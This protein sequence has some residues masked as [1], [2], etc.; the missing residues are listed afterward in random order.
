[1]L[2]RS[3]LEKLEEMSKA[4]K[5]GIN[6]VEY[7]DRK[8]HEIP[9][10]TAKT[11]NIYNLAG[12]IDYLDRNIDCLAPNETLIHVISYDAV[13]V[14][15]RLDDCYRSREDIVKALPMLPD[16]IL[17]RFMNRESFNIML[18]ACFVKTE[19]RDEV[20]EVISKISKSENNGVEL[21]DNGIG[22]SVEVMTGSVLKTKKE[23]PNPVKLAPFR[24]FHEIE[25]PE[26]D[27]VLRVNDSLEVGLFE[28]DGGAWKIEAM[29]SIK[30][31]L[32]EAFGKIYCIIA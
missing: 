9:L 2:D 31:Y 1:M 24:T 11:L 21:V 16:I 14:R 29:S 17:G 13:M 18:Q 8:L 25:Q 19:M 30:N 10:K 6:G 27:F 7:S 20:L 15:S 5:L 28:A 23:I 4:N 3:F 22:Q 32:T 12:L 26:S